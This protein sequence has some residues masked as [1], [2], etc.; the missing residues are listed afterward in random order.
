MLYKNCISNFFQSKNCCLFC[1]FLWKFKIIVVC[2]QLQL[3]KQT[4][5]APIF[6]KIST[7]TIV[8][9]EQ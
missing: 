4:C 6:G 7:F 5:K 2:I 9:N 3:N 8:R 1:H